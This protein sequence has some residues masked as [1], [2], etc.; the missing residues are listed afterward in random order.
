MLGMQVKMAQEIPQLSH[1]GQLV[2]ASYHI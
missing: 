2:V 1:T